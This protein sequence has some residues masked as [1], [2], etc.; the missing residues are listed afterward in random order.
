MSSVT[1][2]PCCVSLTAEGSI[3]LILGL[4]SIKLYDGCLE[5]S[6]ALG[7]Y[8]VIKIYEVCNCSLDSFYSFVHI[9]L[10]ICV[11]VFL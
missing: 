6:G 10:C 8:E 9:F 4:C 1:R 7:N 3:V 11:T 5:T 2:L